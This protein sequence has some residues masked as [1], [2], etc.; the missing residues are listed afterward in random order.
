M[1]TLNAWF[2]VFCPLSIDTLIMFKAMVEQVNATQVTPEEFLS[3]NVY[4]FDAQTQELSVYDGQSEAMN[5]VCL[6]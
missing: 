2:R 3:N 4:C 1:K 5:Q 6:Q